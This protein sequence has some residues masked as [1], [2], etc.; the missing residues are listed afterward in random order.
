MNID[1]FRLVGLTTIN[2]P[3]AGIE[4]TEKYIVKGADG[5]GPPDFDVFTADGQFL[6]RTTLDREVVLRIGLNPDWS[7]GQ[8][9]GDLRD[10][11]YG[12]LTGNGTF[13][14]PRKSFMY[15]RYGGADVAYTETY[16]KRIEIVPF[17]KDPEVQI[18]FRCPDGYFLGSTV[19]TPPAIDTSG[20]GVGLGGSFLVENLGTA[21]SGLRFEIEITDVPGSPFFFFWL[22]HVTGTL[23][24][25]YTFNVGDRIQ[26]SSYDG[27]R[28]IKALIDPTGSAQ[29]I[30]LL[31]YL[32][33][34]HSKFPIVHGGMNEFTITGMDFEFLSFATRTRYWGI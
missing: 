23:H 26:F 11:L 20:A 30:D 15:F 33:L 13:L 1:A 5:L 10:E 12:L 29:E 21:H 34:E 4:T 32:D 22:D 28:Y 7:T 9:A 25:D 8:T 31:S 19:T 3:M 16:V 6:N 2:L 24:V 14:D 17:S 27:D 18:T